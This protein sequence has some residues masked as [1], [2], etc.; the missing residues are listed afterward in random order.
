MLKRLFVMAMLT[1]SATVYADTIKI[2]IPFAPGGVADAAGRIIAKQLNERLPE[3]NFVPEI[4]SSS[5]GVVA[6]QRLARALGHETI[7]MIHSVNIVG[8]STKPGSQYTMHDVQPIVHVGT[9]PM[10]LCVNRDGPVNTLHKFMTSA[11]F[12]GS[13][14]IGS[15]NSIAMAVLQQQNGQNMTHIPYKGEVQALIDV[16]GNNLES[17]FSSLSGAKPYLEDG[18]VIALGVTGNKRHPAMPNVPTLLEQG[19]KGVD[20]PI[21]WLTLFSNNSADPVLIKKIQTA[22]DTALKQ[23][24]DAY[25]K[26]GL[27]VKDRRTKDLRKFME[28]EAIKLYQLAPA[29]EPRK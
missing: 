26:L 8:A 22:L 20:G 2:L 29:L 10:F 21:N 24:P 9:F 6:T 14:G 12:Y 25:E 27:I 18:R 5:G 1:V 16:A 13:S 23:T 15:G 4:Q 3:H 19:V 11:K 7:L 28:S 17:V